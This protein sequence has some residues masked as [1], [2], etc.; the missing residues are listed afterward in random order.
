MLRR[1]TSPFNPPK[2]KKK[3]VLGGKFFFLSNCSKVVLIAT[4]D[5]GS[6]H[7]QP[8]KDALKRLGVKEPILKPF[9]GSFAFIGYAGTNK[10]SWIAQEQEARY[11][12][13][14]IIHLRIP[15]QQGPPGKDLIRISLA[16]HC[17]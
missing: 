2:R 7:W 8:A 3:P 16:F 11:Q 17:P 12:G 10:P 5:S 14:S 9:R 1:S 13:P 6:H 15:L 4:Q